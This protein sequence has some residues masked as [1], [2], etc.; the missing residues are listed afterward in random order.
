MKNLISI[1]CILTIVLVNQ[2]CTKDYSSPGQVQSQATTQIEEKGSA[3]SH[4]KTLYTELY[5][6]YGLNSLV[7]Q[8]GEEAWLY[9]G[10]DWKTAILADGE[11]AEEQITEAIGDLV[12]LFPGNLDYSPKEYLWAFKTPASNPKNQAALYLYPLPSM[13]TPAALAQLKSDL[14]EIVTAATLANGGYIDRASDIPQ[15]AIP[16]PT[17]SYQIASQF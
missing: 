5:N 11:T 1:I 4:P 2:S 14:L 3:N 6:Q 8:Y 17:L 13:Q 12:P 15:N 16:K 7:G 10:P 9:I